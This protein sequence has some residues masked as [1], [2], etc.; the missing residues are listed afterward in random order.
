MTTLTAAEAR[1]LAETAKNLV[2]LDAIMLL[3]RESCLTGGH[4]VQTKTKLTQEATKTLLAWGY[5]VAQ[6][7]TDDLVCW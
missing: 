2:G 1:K 4:N 7:S 6:G 5:Q 3:I